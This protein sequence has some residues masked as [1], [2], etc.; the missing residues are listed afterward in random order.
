MKDGTARDGEMKDGRMK[1]EDA[2]EVR[3]DMGIRG[4]SV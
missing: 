2:R 1:D 4:R 3:K